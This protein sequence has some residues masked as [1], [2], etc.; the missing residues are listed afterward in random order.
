MHVTGKQ[1][2][3]DDEKNIFNTKATAL[4]YLDHQH[5]AM[6]GLKRKSLGGGSTDGAKSPSAEASSAK[7][8][9]S[10][11]PA[12]PSTM[13][14][15]SAQMDF[16]RG[17]GSGLTPFEHASTLR[18][19]RAEMAKSARGDDDL[20]KSGDKTSASSSRKTLSAEDEQQRKEDRRKVNRERNNAKKKKIAF[21]KAAEDSKGKRKQANKD[22]NRIEHLNYKRL[23]PGTRLLCSIAAVHPLAL[24]LSL[25]NQL[26]GHVPITSISPLFTQKLHE[27]ADADSDDEQSDEEMNYSEAE[28]AADRST[29]TVNNNT[30]RTQLATGLPELRD[31]F[32]VGQW[33][34]ASVVSVQAPG[35]TKK[36]SAPG[37]QAHEFDK[38]SR[39]VELT[40]APE[41][42]NDGLTPADVS[43]GFVLPV[44]IKS[45][46]DHGFL[47]DTGLEDIQGFA[48]FGQVDAQSLYLGQVITAT[49]V[50]VASAGRSFTA[51]LKA[52][53][54]QSASLGPE[55]A[56]SSTALIPGCQVSA[57]ITASLPN[58]LNAKLWGMFDATIDSFHLPAPLPAGKE[59]HEVYKVGS[60]IKTRILWE[61][62]KNDIGNLVGNQSGSDETAQRAIGLSAAPHVLGL[63]APDAGK[64]KS[65]L[66]E[67]PIGAKLEAKVVHTDSE[68]GL[69]CSI[70]GSTIQGFAHISRVSD[71]HVV[72]LPSRSGPFALGTSHEARVVGHAPTDRLLL[73]SFQKSTLEKSFMRVSEV[74]VGS[75]V[76][77]TVNRI[78][79]NGSAIFLNLGG[80][81][82]GVVFPLHFAD[83]PLKKPEKKYKPGAA[84]KARVV[85]VDSAKN[86]IVLTLKKSLVSSDLPMISSI[87]DARIG[88]VTQATV[89]KFVEG[90]G[91]VVDLFGGLR[92]F[93]PTSEATE[94]PL[95][96]SAP[97]LQ[98]HFY[99]GKVVKIRLTHVDYESEKLLAS[100]KQ[101]SPTFLAKLD[102]AA[103]QAGQRV[104]ASIAAVHQDVVV[105]ELEPSKVRGLLSL[106]VLAKKR[107]TTVEELKE[108]LQ[109][110]EVLEDLVVVDKHAE[111]G[112]VIVGDAQAPVHKPK[113][114]SGL[115]EPL[116][117]GT[118]H[119][120]RVAQNSGE[121]NVATVFL[122]GGCRARLHLTDVA[123]NFDE[124]KLP[125]ANENVQV[126]LL[127]LRNSGKRA[128]V[129][130]RSSKLSSTGEPS[131]VKDAEVEQ[132][133]DLKVGEKRRGFV[134][135][136]SP[137]GLFVD[138]GRNTTA[139]VLISELF[140]D[141]VKEWQSRFTVGQLV[142]GTVTAIDAG[143]SKVEL[144]L[145]SSPGSSKKSKADRE[146]ARQEAK[147]EARAKQEAG[148]LKFKDLSKGMKV[149]AFVKAVQEYGV[150]VQIEN[151]QIS[152]LAHKSQLT[153]NASA[154]SDP[155]KAFSVGD[156]VKA[157]ILEVHGGEKKKVDFG[158]KP[159]YFSAE[160]FEEEEGDE[161]EEQQDEDEEMGS[162]EEDDEEDD[163]D[164]DEDEQMDGD[165]DS[166][167]EI[168]AEALLQG[169]SDDESDADLLELHDEDSDEDEDTADS[170]DEEEQDSDSDSDADTKATSTT[171][172]VPALELSGGFSWSVP[173]GNAVSADAG[174]DSD[175]ESSDEETTGGKR[176]ASSLK[177]PKAKRGRKL[178]IEEDLTA[179]LANKAPESSADFERMLLSSPNS[180]YLW[181]QFMS[182]QL[183]LADVEQAREVARRALKVIN[184]R[185]EQEKLNVWIAL[186]NLEN[187]Y[188]TDES[189]ESTFREAIQRNDAKIVH[190][191]MASILEKTEKLDKAIEMWKRTSKK[192]GNSPEVWVAFEHFYLRNGKADE[193]RAL[194]PRSMQSL[195]KRKHVETI[196]AFGL[197]EFKLGDVER[198]RT[199]FE[200][201]VDSYPKRL[202]L[203]WQYID[204]ESS[205][206]N[207]SQAR[208]LFERVLNLKQSAKKVKSVL[209]KW[210]DFEKRYGDKQGEQEVLSR[211]RS[212]VEE[213][214][215]KKEKE[216]AQDDDE[217]D[218]EDDEQED[219][220]SDDE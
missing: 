76:R 216:G 197:G 163:E 27:A 198:G 14:N 146:A 181:I 63:S 166:D 78:G 202:D 206:K 145:R 139:R 53:D 188:G 35:V 22:H 59:M 169:Q 199:I 212:F 12:P 36:G 182:F 215:A 13:L 19:A 47:L 20:F 208:S 77:A 165:S 191:R 112:I 136:I 217:E 125:S 140:D 23:A 119:T 149:N 10:F 88:V 34:R 90:R 8:S 38:E 2:V 79:S 128:D 200:G 219:E 4:D 97:T 194:L 175:D 129:T 172:A 72:K 157:V 1:Q 40:L 205:L 110:G 70:K 102:V 89:S 170:D 57:L 174:S 37:T 171:S 32:K 31:C 213:L 93:V 154:A 11:E 42:I 65:L 141:Y 137:A 138:L 214:N 7:K 118:V 190:L 58:G 164:D 15:D 50:S 69:T 111:K 132:A 196:S 95:G 159:S 86:R 41:A 162:G 211:A 123:D 66:E 26:V 160:D 17:G 135:A 187:T 83:V 133:S 142:S 122:A 73:L 48:P 94:S 28:E 39:R 161:D 150:F 113:T 192:F 109:D 44:A 5:L 147:N 168:D 167:V 117:P 184:Y 6:P 155:T 210:L 75:Q 64:K 43:K 100:V 130:T 99:E 127:R 104:T 82:E 203:W 176:K 144:S 52:K 121:T 108:Q 84:V 173:D 148:T 126:H 16:P 62:Q 124:A 189:L 178:D 45:K 87:Q 60:K 56:P 103:V 25:P 33:V 185:E 96:P 143:H 177:K 67:Y 186:L 116:N 152:G 151:T 114:S 201:L 183:Q 21:G 55:S 131:V 91:M 220:E 101:A 209:K 85:N 74:E 193:A 24:I 195:E 3:C 92:A 61:S 81:F 54:A 9:K 29:A 158:L 49:V 204:Q 30:K 98:S 105:L 115:A 71:D 218:Q 179:D 18:E 107:G 68:W 156:R 134:K 80:A 120:G 180:S 207:I 106:N 46:E 153:D 51:S